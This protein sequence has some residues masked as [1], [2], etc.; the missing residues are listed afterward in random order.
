M[1]LL[2]YDNNDKTLSGDI[3]VYATN[4][5]ATNIY[6]GAVN[7]GDTLIT[8]QA[9]IDALEG[10]IISSGTT[11]YYGLFGS[12]NNA[13]NPL[14]EKSFYFNQ[15]IQTNGFS[16]TGGTGLS[17]TRI[18]AANAAVYNIYY[19]ANY[20]KIDATTAYEVR[21][22]LMKNGTDLN[23]STTLHTL[24][25]TA[26]WQQ[27]SGQYI[28]SLAAGDYLE[29]QWL[30][31]N[32]SASS[33]ILDSIGISAPYPQVSAM[34]ACIQQVANT[35][36]GLG[37]IFE[38]ASTNT[39]PAGSSATVVDTTTTF[40]TYINH[41]LVFGIPQ[42]LQGIN[43]T[44]GTNGATGPTGP[45]GPKGDKG[46]KGDQGEKG[47][48]GDGPIAYAALSL[49]GVAEA[50]AIAAGAA[51]ATALSQ[52][53]AQDA[54]IAANTAD[55]ATDEGR[56]T[57]LEVKT[58]DQSWGTFTGTTFSRRVQITNTGAAPGV[59]AVYLGSS[60]A[61]TFLYGLSS[62][63]NI[64][65]TG[66]ITST[67]GT[68]QVS[69][70][71][72]NNNME[73]TNDTFITAGELYL[74]RTLLNN[75]KKLILYDNATGND[76][77][78]LGFWTM[79]GAT[80]RKFFNAEID[81]NANSAFQW[82]YGDGVGLSRTLMKSMN[83]TLETSFIPTSKF[84]KSPGFTQE[85]A[86]VKD[87]PNNRV[88]IDMIGD[89]GLI[90]NYDGQIIQE[91][92]NGVM[93]NTGLMTI[94]SGSLTLN[95]LKAATG[96]IEMNTVI[97][98]INTTGAITA[99]SATTITL[100]STGETEINSAALDINATGAITMDST[101]TTTLTS[102]GTTQINSAALDINAT[103][104]ITADSATTIT[105]TSVGETEINC[106]T[107]DINATGAITADTPSTFT[108]TS[109]SNIVM[110][111]DLNINLNANYLLSE[112]NLTT[113]GDGSNINLNSANE[114]FLLSERLL[115]IRTVDA[116][117]GEIIID[118]AKNLNID[119]A[120]DIS[121]TA[122]T[123][124]GL[125]GTAIDLTSTTGIIDINAETALNLRSDTNNIGLTT[126]SAT[127]DIN[128]TSGRD[129]NFS[130]NT[131]GA[132]ANFTSNKDQDILK[133]NN[134]AF[135][136]KLLI[137]SATTGFR[138]SVNNNTSANLN[139]L[140][141]TQVNLSTNNAQMNLTAGGIAGKLTLTSSLDEVEINSVA[142]DVNATGAITMD[143]TTTTTLTSAGETEINSAALDINATGAITMD[144]PTTTTLTSAGET[145]INCAALDI[146]AT[147]A[148][149]MD[150]DDPITITSTANGITLSS[151]G[152]QDITCGSL[153]IN[154]NGTIAI[155][156]VSNNTITSGGNLNLVSTTNDVAVNGIVKIN[157]TN[158]K[159]TSIGN[160][161]GA[162]AL[163]GS[164]N[165]ILGTTNINRTNSL[166]TNIG[167]SGALT[168][169][170]SSYS[171]ITTGDQTFTSTTGDLS[172]TKTGAT[173]GINFT[174]AN[175]V[176]IDATDEFLFN[177]GGLCELTT[178]GGKIVLQANQD[179]ELTA[180]NFTFNSL[181]SGTTYNGYQF[182]SN[183]DAIDFI[184]ENPT[185]LSTNIQIGNAT[186]GFTID[187]FDDNLASLSAK[188]TTEIQLITAGGNINFVCGNTANSMLFRFGPTPTT[189]ITISDGGTT[190]AHALT[191]SS[192]T[193][194]NSTCNMNHDFLLQ[195]STYPPTS[196]SA[197]GY[198]GN[199]SQTTNPMSNT[200]AERMNFSIPSKGVWLIVG[201]LYWETNTSNTVEVKEAVI[202]TTSGSGG[203]SAAAPGL[204]YYDEINDA[205]GAA[206][207]RQHLNINGV[208]TA[209]AATTLYCN[210]RSGVNSGTN[211][212]FNI[213]AT[214]TRIG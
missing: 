102:T 138:T 25:T 119:T 46:N 101:S 29:I 151:F 211:T 121:L 194:M 78:Y 32:A 165:T 79:D 4:V 41:S 91:Q 130:L 184:F 196:T 182:T 181:H 169:N 13:S 114:M 26:Q 150:T 77:D 136:S 171:C 206:G 173:G 164:T 116:A 81:G 118:S 201:Q 85:I 50:T 145:E 60:D 83:Q 149:T 20:Q 160:A 64:S 144:T 176:F 135:D 142:F 70:L 39:L 65:T 143:T 179:M 198:T 14:A 117:D 113:T 87:A 122:G 109:A 90:G 73:I 61:S 174:S 180:R 152:E 67:V 21:T 2:G 185:S 71:L 110:N 128:L 199:K 197:I 84:L 178:S 44:N 47:E 30:S 23:Y 146:N 19:K 57:V 62:S 82:Y 45:E 63:G 51:A 104:E 187:V 96:E 177:A 48:N 191:M 125:N 7:V 100:T 193:T 200:L 105:L 16:I 11:G 115:D 12:S 9:E 166:A 36:T 106:S 66:T 15:T 1:S 161:T 108:I 189:K 99:D 195:Q 212:I 159:A 43:G 129:I 59:D 133:I 148:I 17:A 112:I 137:G 93:D 111:S 75:Q 3:D 127:G 202:S 54:L 72:V 40:P 56:I 88:R 163:T 94:Q 192:T 210:A 86:L 162:L 214:W 18:T 98:D 186:D 172:F 204:I 124:I 10:Q 31:T 157:T 207:K 167:N 6:D 97:L 153:D 49:A 80:G 95:A 183:G 53:T 131:T 74:T 123:T 89:T 170:G 69:S 27:I 38:V 203:S 76:Y 107:L 168:L 52:N 120:T 5:Y 34:F 58:Q 188:A 213:N 24:S 156:S 190:F 126:I 154:S 139:G 140:G 55:I 92:G 155:D 8:L 158:T 37:A 132:I 22:W 28:V 33:D 205:A 134:T 68:S 208:Y 141:Q 42:G 147:G 103:A 35:D 209:T 175:Y